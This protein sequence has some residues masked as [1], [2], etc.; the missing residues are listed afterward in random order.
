MLETTSQDKSQEAVLR[1]AAGDIAATLNGE[2]L[3]AIELTPLQS[4]PADFDILCVVDERRFPPWR[5]RWGLLRVPWV[6]EVQLVSAHLGSAMRPADFCYAQ[7]A[8]DKESEIFYEFARRFGNARIDRALL[9]LQLP[10]DGDP[11]GS[12]FLFQGEGTFEVKQ[13]KRACAAAG[14]KIQEGSFT[15]PEAEIFFTENILI[16]SH[17]YPK[18]RVPI[19]EDLAK[20][21][22]GGD[23]A[24]WIH[25]RRVPFASRLP[26]EGI[27]SLTIRA[28]FEGGVAVR[29]E[30]RFHDEASA[31]KSAE[32]IG[33]WKT[34]DLEPAPLADVNPAAVAR[35]KAFLGSLALSMDGSTVVAK[36]SAPGETPESL[37]AGVVDLQTL[38]DGAEEET[39]DKK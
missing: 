2:K 1:R 3:P 23:D 22:L 39:E 16:A 24:I 4:V 38:Y 28:K 33:K 31:R 20:M 26:V 5:D 36:W 34:L 21:G 17:A 11:L 13:I 12:K 25:C 29:A 9:A 15:L 35:V 27:E 10:E 18:G 7:W 6:R 32:A 14:V 8:L 30:A 37:L 19:P